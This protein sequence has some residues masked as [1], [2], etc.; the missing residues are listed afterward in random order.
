MTERKPAGMPFSSWVEAQVARAEARGAFTD[1]PGAGRP[2]PRRDSAET[3]YDWVVAWAR[4]EE[5][6]VTGMLPP[7]LALRRERELL[8]GR[9]ARMPSEVA[10]RAVVEDFNDRVRE[11]WR[12]PA[13]G[14]AVVV[15]L[16]DVD[17]AVAR[18][19]QERPPPEPPPR[20]PEDLPRR[21][22]WR[23]RRS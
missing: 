2:L 16:V 17:A 19:R 5:A 9:L 6:D 13:D 20:P 4:R 3:S 8:P 15:G 10:V 18:W 11:S 12:R 23:R 21:R 7:A 14:P 1:L 22:W